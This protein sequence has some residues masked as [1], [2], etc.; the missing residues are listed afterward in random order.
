MFRSGILIA[1]LAFSFTVFAD[2]IDE[3]KNCLSHWK[4]HPFKSDAPEFRT[5]DA[6][7]K[8]MGVGDELADTAKTDKPEL[9][10]IKPSVTVL[11]KSTMKLTNPN[12]W[13]CLKGKVS[14]L[15]RSDIQLHCSARLASAGSGA[16]VLAS[17]DNSTGVT[18][19]GKSTLTR[20][21]CPEKKES[22]Q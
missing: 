8:V 6:K 20:V 16:T 7:V 11:S 3:V 17:D 2:D 22:V 10:L 14:V 19:L 15:G 12:G 21:G 5:I 13:Y 4:N 18:V 1:L 9:V